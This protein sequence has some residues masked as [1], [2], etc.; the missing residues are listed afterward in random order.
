M[1]FSKPTIIVNAHTPQ[2]LEMF[3]SLGNV[4]ALETTAIT[5]ESVRR[6][7]ILIVRSETRID[8]Q[9]LK[10]SS[11]RFV[12]TVT[13][14]T[15][16][17][18]K[19]YLASKG[20]LWSSAPGSNSNSVAEYVAAALLVW[21]GKTGESLEGKT[22]G[23]VGVG[24]VGSKVVRIAKAF[25][26]NVV[27]NDPP[28]A[29]TTGESRYLS[30]DEAISADVISL[31][32]PLIKEGV[33]AT[34]HLFD[35][36]RLMKIQR[37]A[38][39]INT[40]RGAV[41]ESAALQRALTSHQLSTAILD[42]WEHEPDINV[43]VLTQV[44]IGTPHIAGY[45]LDGKLN[46]LKKVYDDVC[47]FLGTFPGRNL[48]SSTQ[49]TKIIVPPSFTDTLEIVAFVVNEAY[50]IEIDD[51]ALRKLPVI[52]KCERGG[53]FRRLRAEY[54]NRREFGTMVVRLSG[55]QE[56]AKTPLQTLGFNVQ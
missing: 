47:K 21:S 22:L 41:V 37:G 11:V 13:A 29:R 12:G 27:L 18:D 25:G 10:G 50:N 33:D 39:L 56:T 34:Y 6:A 51:A 36:E 54:R 20:I 45:S 16:H 17:L 35:E 43:D 48:S 19:E 31:H 53:Y 55:I 3:S 1:S 49:A 9:L 30:L 7:E 5:N 8:E 4:C 46:A 24:N 44:M 15:D 14:G 40:S 28:L 26:M 32:V 38:V 42:V 2:A 52:P 23:V